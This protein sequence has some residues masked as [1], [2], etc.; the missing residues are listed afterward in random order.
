MDQ[1]QRGG[2]KTPPGY[3][4]AQPL[5]DP[6]VGIDEYG[7]DAIPGKPARGG[8]VE[9][10]LDARPE[11]LCGPAS[12]SRPLLE[13]QIRLLAGGQRGGA[14]TTAPVVC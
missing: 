10:L 12:G 11:D 8:V 3:E 5:A 6:E 13:P 2:G 9:G 7:G 4:D 14:G 1:G